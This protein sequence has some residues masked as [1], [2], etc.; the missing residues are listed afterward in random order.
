M[1][2]EPI[3]YTTP[4]ASVK[5]YAS[6]EYNKKARICNMHFHTE[7]ELLYVKKGKMGCYTDEKSYLAE[8]GEIIFINSRVPHYT[9]YL[10]DGT[11]YIMVQ[12]VNPVMLS[13]GVKYLARYL[14][15]TEVACHVFEKEQAQTESFIEKIKKLSEETLSGLKANEF[16]ILSTIYEIAGFLRRYGYLYDEGDFPDQKRLNEIMPM[17]DYIEEHYAENIT[18]ADVS[19]NV[20]LNRNYICRLFKKATGGTLMD[21]LN[22]VRVCKSEKLLKEGM[23]VSETSDRSGFSSQSYFYKVFK[24][25]N[26][27][28]PSQYKKM[29]SF[30]QKH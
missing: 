8:A 9:E 15:K 3:D 17:I 25:Y 12:V 24:K 13:G 1:H 22:F 27:L 14:A 2:N 16:Y 19:S 6:T 20:N 7:I 18:L 10:E 5:V 4:N 29:R 21:Y 30:Q 28:A 23:S 11:D 26:F